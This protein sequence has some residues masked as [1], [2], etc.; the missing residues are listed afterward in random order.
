MQSFRSLGWRIGVLSVT[1]ALGVSVAWAGRIDGVAAYVNDDVLT[2]NDV[3]KGSRELQAALSGYGEDTSQQALNAMYL[4]S[5]TNAVA[6]LLMIDAYANETRLKIPE[7]AIDERASLIIEERF[8]GDRMRLGELLNKEGITLEQWREQIKEQIILS[9]MR[10]LH[11][12]SRVRLAPG[13]ARDAYEAQREEF[14]TPRRVKLRML[15][16]KTDGAAEKLQVEKELLALRRRLTEEKA[17]FAALATEFSQGSRA[18][19]GGDRGW[20]EPEMLRTELAAAM[21]L[22]E[23]G[24]ISP[25]V[26]AGGSLYLL[27]AEEVDAGRVAPFAEVEAMLERRLRDEQGAKVFDE[28]LRILRRKAYVKILEPSP[29]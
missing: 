14:V 23:A 17:D 1:L 12:E 5:M 25:V 29:F 4:S 21:V 8:G 2:I 7:E 6:R 16:M 9:A 27:F 18:K 15:M 13:A 20:M 10:N 22:L 26:D 24:E 3:I 11:V 28:W 19:D